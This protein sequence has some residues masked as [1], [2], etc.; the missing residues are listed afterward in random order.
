MEKNAL[1]WP[2]KLIRFRRFTFGLVLA[3]VAVSVPAADLPF[4]SGAQAAG[5]GLE[6]DGTVENP[7]QISDQNDLWGVIDCSGLQSPGL[8]KYFELT[9]DI[10]VNGTG[11]TAFPIGATPDSPT[12]SFIAAV[13]NGKGFE[14]SYSIDV[15][16]ADNKAAGLFYALEDVTISNLVLR[17]S[18]SGGSDDT[19]ENTGALAH[20]AEGN[21]FLQSISSFVTVNGHTNVGGLFGMW[22]G[23]GIHG[24]LRMENVSNY[25][26]VI[27][28]GSLVGG[29]IGYATENY[30]L[31][32]VSNA[33]TV[34]GS[35]YVGG[36]V[37]Q[38]RFRTASLSNSVNSGAVSSTNGYLGGI[39]GV[40]LNA[41]TISM[42]SV[43]N[44]GPVSSPS[45]NGVV[46]GLIG[47]A[48]SGANL[49]LVS[50]SNQAPIV[51]KDRTGGL[52]GHYQGSGLEISA[53]Q[54]IGG[55]TGAEEVGGLVGALDGTGKSTFSAVANS[56]QI[57]GSESVGGLVGLVG[58][59]S[60]FENSENLGTVSA[61]A[62]Y[63]GG[64][65]GYSPNSR[66]FRFESVSNRGQVSGGG[67]FSGGIFGEMQGSV[68]LTSVTN[69]A[70]V[71]AQSHT[72]GGLGGYANVDQLSI[73]QSSN[74]GEVGCTNRAGGLVGRVAEDS[75]VSIYR[76]SNQASISA[77]A[78]D[79]GG[80][81]GF[82]IDDGNGKIEILESFN[83][84]NISG[85]N[86]SAGLVGNATDRDYQ[87]TRSYSVGLISGG[88]TSGLVGSDMAAA[89]FTSI[90]ESYV[91]ESSGQ[92]TFNDGLVTAATSTVLVSVYT[93]ANSSLTQSVTVA[94]LKVASTYVDWNFDTVWGFGGC[95]LNN[96]YPVLRWAHDG[97]TLYDYSCGVMSSSSP[98]VVPGNT[99]GN[100][101]A[102]NPAP[103]SYQGPMLESHQV[104][105][106]VKE[107]VVV[108][109]LR[110]ESILEASVGGKVAQI[111]Q[112]TSTSIAIT[113]PELE[114]GA[115]D[116]VVQGSHGVLTVTL[117]FKVIEPSKQVASSSAAIAFG[118]LLGFR[119]ISKF[120]GNSR[121]L[122]EQQVV[123]VSTALGVFTNATTI[124]CWGYTKDPAPNDWALAHATK[125]AASL[126]NEVT[127]LRDDVRVF[128][129][130]QIGVNRYAAM[131]ATMQFWESKEPQ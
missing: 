63:A 125:R 100:T 129:R 64:I 10:V 68:S 38:S 120:D 108:K 83:T 112:L 107:V 17:G 44:T 46:G 39:I 115:F 11:V 13:I 26:Q 71:S 42:T 53:S 81:L 110:L 79:A 8:E 72:C 65:V 58:E 76:S 15:S 87:I 16:T 4:V 111:S 93:F 91:G 98:V 102:T 18:V 50:V 74:I 61:T 114:P 2:E 119:W 130:V 54:N 3:L 14:I 70:T 57:T 23:S 118:D 25:G 126:C 96:G 104:T 7:Y 33:A 36:L 52:I 88:T 94:D 47:N 116:L 86:H 12:T 59:D 80:I 48:A 85:S 21:V 103:V 99:P 51:G 24:H 92:P 78:G 1:T 105:V 117:K 6:E 34:S 66:D 75:P 82:L 113:I 67:A 30:E 95:D 123:L 41:V 77:S 124:V 62:D 89:G 55:V 56:G 101:P 9:Q 29:L 45:T 22:G 73:S 28:S 27:G 35:F 127:A 90:A 40:T 32:S 60:Y 5:C 97:T 31:S 37:G 84:G 69:F 49:S 128:V 131:R 20:I 122:T 106:V 109:G 43:A 19:D 121:D